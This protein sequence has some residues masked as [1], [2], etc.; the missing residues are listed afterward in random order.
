MRER[1]DVGSED[2][3]HCFNPCVFITFTAALPPAELCSGISGL[4][5][6]EGSFLRGVS[7]GQQAEGADVNPAPGDK[8]HVE[9]IRERQREGDAVIYEGL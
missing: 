6:G 3:S 1:H 5:A 7:R 2:V 4:W 8:R 9:L